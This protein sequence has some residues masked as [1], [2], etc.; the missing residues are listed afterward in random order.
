MV[1][2]PEH[3]FLAEHKYLIMLIFFLLLNSW[4]ILFGSLL[5]SVK[6]SACDSI[7][8]PISAIIVQMFRLLP[9]LLNRLPL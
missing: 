7:K 1:E 9:V 5:S 3:I 8:C 2:K 6:L 4:L